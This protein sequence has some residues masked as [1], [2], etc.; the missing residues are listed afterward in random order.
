ML[1]AQKMFLIHP[2]ISSHYKEHKAHVF[3]ISMMIVF[4]KLQEILMLIHFRTTNLLF[5][6]LEDM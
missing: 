4:S 3:E 2:C 6:F 1:K 5:F